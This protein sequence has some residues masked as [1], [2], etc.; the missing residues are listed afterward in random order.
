MSNYLKKQMDDIL[1]KVEEFGEKAGEGG[2]D[3]GGM[4]IMMPAQ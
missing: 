1:I 3:G 4:T 2:K